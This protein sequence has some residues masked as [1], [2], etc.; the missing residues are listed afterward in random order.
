M[1]EWVGGQRRVGRHKERIAIRRLMMNVK[2]SQCSIRPRAI[3]DDDWL[4]KQGGE[5]FGD[6]AATV[7]LP[8]PGP[9]TLTK[10]IGHEG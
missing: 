5:M 6:D 9:N 1:Y 7:S 10:V 4:A 8:L 3:F 2:S